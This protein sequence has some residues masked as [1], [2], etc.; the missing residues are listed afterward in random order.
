MIANIPKDIM[1]YIFGRNI[2]KTLKRKQDISFKN[3]GNHINFT[4]CEI[5]LASFLGLLDTKLEQ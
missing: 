3:I 1:T 4:N 2:C 5:S